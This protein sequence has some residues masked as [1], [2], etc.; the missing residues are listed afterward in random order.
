[1]ASD[2]Q[3]MHP[4]F[5]YSGANG[6]D[7]FSG[8]MNTGMT[9]PSSNS[10]ASARQMMFGPSY[11]HPVYPTLNGIDGFSGMMESAFTPGS[12]PST[13]SLPAQGHA[14]GFGLPNE[15]GDQENEFPGLIG[16]SDQQGPGFDFAFRNPI[17]DEMTMGQEQPVV[18][19]SSQIVEPPALQENQQYAQLLEGAP[20]FGTTA[21]EPLQVQDDEQGSSYLGI[22]DTWYG[23]GE[24]IP[25]SSGLNSDEEEMARLLSAYNRGE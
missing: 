6:V 12:G 23:G 18:D 7:E 20:E 4:S 11:P 2:G 16:D 10:M 9:L 24:E 8:P 22:D 3:M 5:H 21:V 13:R 14:V 15:T 25:T 1:M 19:T 17:E